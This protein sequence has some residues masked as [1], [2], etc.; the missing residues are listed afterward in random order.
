MSVGVDASLASFVEA[1]CVVSVGCGV[2]VGGGSG[3][4]VGGSGVLV[5]GGVLVAEGSTVFVGGTGVF[6]G[7]GELVSVGRGVLVGTGVNVRVGR[8][9]A[10]AVGTEPEKSFVLVGVSRTRVR[11]GIRL[12][13]LVNKAVGEETLVSESETV[14]VG[15]YSAI[16][17]TVSAATVLMFEMAESTSPWGLIAI[18]VL[19]IPGP[20]TAAADTMQNRLNPTSPD[21]STVRGAR[22]SLM[23]KGDFSYG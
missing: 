3:V 21:V 12:G 23:F 4:L 17:S 5:G 22:Y 7:T 14:G 1:G 18:G 19:A 9:V 6:V 8:R 2:L 10:V 15:M 13:V 16:D 20:A 11:V